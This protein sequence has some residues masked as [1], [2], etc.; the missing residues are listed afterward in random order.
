MFCNIFNAENEAA[1]A[2]RAIGSEIVL[3]RDHRNDIYTQIQNLPEN[4]AGLVVRFHVPEA[5]NWVLPSLNVE[6]RNRFKMTIRLFLNDTAANSC[7]LAKQLSIAIVLAVGCHVSRKLVEI[8]DDIDPSTTYGQF[9][10]TLQS[11][12]ACHPYVKLIDELWGPIYEA[13]AS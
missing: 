12:P 7:D 4:Q 13:I 10:E 9:M 6:R 3:C 8:Y 2:T 1:K 11:D 5:S